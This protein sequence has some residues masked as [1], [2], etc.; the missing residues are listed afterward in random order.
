[1]DDGS[2]SYWNYYASGLWRAGKLTADNVENFKTLCRLLALADAIGTEIGAAR[3]MAAANAGEMS[4]S[5][6][7]GI[8]L[9]AHRQTA[10]LLRQFGLV[11]NARDR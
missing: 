10:P 4:R 11:G 7:V 6:A 1:L 3:T 5:P 9:Q 8:L 2:L